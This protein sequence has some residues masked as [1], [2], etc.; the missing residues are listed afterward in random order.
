ML[1]RQYWLERNFR[2]LQVVYLVMNSNHLGYITHHNM[3][4]V[5]FLPHLF[6]STLRAGT[7]IAF[8]N[9]PLF[10]GSNAKVIWPLV[11][12]RYD[13]HPSNEYFI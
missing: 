2:T 5:T 7:Q 9:V 11:L 8:P 12:I 1:E 3:I 13:L 4:S 10:L 6:F